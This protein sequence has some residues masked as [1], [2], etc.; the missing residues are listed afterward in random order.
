MLTSREEAAQHAIS[1]VCMSVSSGLYYIKRM[2]R[3]LFE[4]C[5]GNILI[6]VIIINGM[7]LSG[8]IMQH[9]CSNKVHASCA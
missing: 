2:L 6:V 5:V 3:N 7:E 1:V 9:N 4:T 8:N